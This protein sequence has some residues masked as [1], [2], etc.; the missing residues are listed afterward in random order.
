MNEMEMLIN[1][2]NDL[3]TD[4]YYE[5][6]YVDGKFLFLNG[7]C[8]NLVKIIQTYVPYPTT[9]IYLKND[10]EHC[11]IKYKNEL[12]DATG[13]IIDYENYKLATPE[14]LLY[15][16]DRFGNHL[17]YLHIYETIINELSMINIS[18]IMDKFSVVQKTL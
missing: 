5:R 16:E 15:M 14:D 3:A 17:E 2:I 8:L 4:L 10:L 13:K 18:H 1:F 11:A 9:Q 7:G 6:L 12:Y